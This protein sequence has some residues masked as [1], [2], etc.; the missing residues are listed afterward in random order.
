MK[1]SNSSNISPNHG[2]TRQTSAIKEDEERIQNII[3]DPE[4]S[5]ILQ[6]PDIQKLLTVLKN[7]PNSA[8]K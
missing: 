4:V 6:S 3:S 5:K 1:N 2:D 7:N 8:Q